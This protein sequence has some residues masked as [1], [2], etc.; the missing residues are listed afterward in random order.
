MPPTVF[1]DRDGVLN[2]KAPEGSYV[3]SSAELK[4]LP[5]A[6][7]AVARLSKAG[8]RI[9]IVTNQQAIGRQMLTVSD[10]D[11]IH[12]AVLGAIAE[13]GGVVHQVM[14]CPHLAGTCCCR[15]PDIGLFAEAARR[16]PG[17][18]FANSFVVGDSATDMEAATAIGARGLHVGGPP[19]DSRTVRDLR[20]AAEVILSS[21]TQKSSEDSRAWTSQ[22]DAHSPASVND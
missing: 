15:K 20:E 9:V 13:E 7:E 16:D 18:N 6:P 19:D 14:V 1:L 22:R 2:Q 12:E 10:L 11:L 5:G 17:I 8:L 21:L 4:M 3:L